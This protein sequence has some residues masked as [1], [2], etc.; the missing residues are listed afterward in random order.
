MYVVSAYVCGGQSEVPGVLLSHSPHFMLM[1]GDRD[2]QP[3]T[4]FCLPPFLSFSAGALHGHTWLFIPVRGSELVSSRLHRVHFFQL[5]HLPKLRTVLHL[6]IYVC[7]L[8]IVYME[9]Q[10]CHGECMEVRGQPTEESVL[11]FHHVGPG[12]QIQAIR[13]GSK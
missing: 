3:R 4:V 8:F 11:F 10:E 7:L 12:D 2:S 13:L 1:L 5:N 6:F 9:V